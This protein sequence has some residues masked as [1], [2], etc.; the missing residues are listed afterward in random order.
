MAE[1]AGLKV[2]DVELNDVNGGSFVLQPQS[3]L[4][5]VVQEEKI[6]QL[7]DAEIEKTMAHRLYMWN[8]KNERRSI[9]MN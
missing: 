9:V 1:R 6:Q 8:L 3:Q 2:L 7:R 5:H 4:S